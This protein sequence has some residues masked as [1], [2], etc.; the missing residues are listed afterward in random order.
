[1]HVEVPRSYL[2]VMMTVEMFGEVVSKIFLTR[3][4]LHVKISLLELVC[5]PKKPHYHG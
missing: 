1:M 4:P 5:G 3:M 2:L